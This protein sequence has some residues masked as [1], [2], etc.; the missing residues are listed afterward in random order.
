MAGLFKVPER[1]GRS[2]DSTIAKKANSKSS[3]TATTVKSGG[4]IVEKINMARAL[5]EKNLGQYRDK[6]QVI[7]DENILTEY[8]DKCVENG[9]ISIDTETTGL[10]PI[11]DEIVGICIYTPDM[12]PSYIPVNHKSYVTQIK[13]E[14]QLSVE[15]IRAE[16]ER[17]NNF[18]TKVIM[19]NAAFDTRFMRNQIG[20]NLVCYWDCYLAARLLNENEGS[21][22]NGLKHLHHKYC[23]SEGSESKFN[24]LFSGITFD[25]VPINIGYLYAAN[26]ALITYELYEFQKQYLLPDSPQC[27]AQQLQDVSWVFFNIEMPCVRVVADMEDTGVDFDME[28]AN[29]LHDIYHDKLKESLSAVYSAIDAYA[30]KVEQY[31]LKNPNNKLSDPINVD[32]PTQIAILLYDILGVKVVDDKSPRGT[33][34]KILSKIDNDITNAILNYRTVEN[35]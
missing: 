5:T 35:L 33:G 27:I 1:A 20:V 6:F 31:R 34:E 12:K 32:S 30:D 22:N 8:I 18:G 17:L 14:G 10:D 28:L 26:D 25:Y 21:G 16:F 23:E 29:K 9:V 3:K 15:F 2:A 11:L 19:F 7:K 4:G 24:D 13:V